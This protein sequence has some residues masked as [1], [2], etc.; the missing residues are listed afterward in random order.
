MVVPANA[1]PI[2]ELRTADGQ[3]FAV[4]MSTEEFAR[5][6][7]E[8]ESLREQVATLQRQKTYYAAELTDILKTWI[9]IPPTE[10]EVLAAVPNSEELSKLIAELEAS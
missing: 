5:M 7:A 1:V 3:V 6:K 8:M 4:V 9:P 2:Q 10:E